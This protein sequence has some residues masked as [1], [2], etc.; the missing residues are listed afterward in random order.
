[1]GPDFG[2]GHES[3]GCDHS[4]RYGSQ[5]HIGCGVR[6]AVRI[7]K[8]GRGEGH[9]RFIPP[10]AGSARRYNCDGI[11]DRPDLT[12]RG[13]HELPAAWLGRGGVCGV[14]SFVSWF[15]EAIGPRRLTPMS[16]GVTWD[17]SGP[18]MMIPCQPGRPK[19]PFDHGRSAA[20][21]RPPNIST[22]T[23]SRKSSAL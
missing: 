1:M 18:H 5:D 4:Q 12:Q 2:V 20:T 15:A 9:D 22:R 10:M 8:N 6:V 19:V 17:C 3:V 14:R 13:H 7:S 11:A 16:P 21:K 23:G